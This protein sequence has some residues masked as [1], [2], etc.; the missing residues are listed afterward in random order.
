MNRNLM[1]IIIVVLVVA[2]GVVGYMYYQDQQ[3]T[4]LDI[5]VGEDGVSIDAS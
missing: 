4:S 2:L 5:S 1:T 3:T